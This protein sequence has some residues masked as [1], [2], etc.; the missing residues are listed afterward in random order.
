MCEASPVSKTNRTGFTSEP[1]ISVKPVSAGDQL[2]EEEDSSISFFSWKRKNVSRK[3]RCKTQWMR[4][5]DRQV[6]ECGCVPYLIWEYGYD[7]I[8]T[9][10]PRSNT[11]T[12]WGENKKFLR[13][14][15]NLL[16]PLVAR[17]SYLIVDCEN[18]VVRLLLLLTE[19]DRRAIQ[20]PFSHLMRWPLR[21]KITL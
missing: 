20:R 3:T 18:D 8:G 19:E 2:L 12:P 7:F 9:R 5:D 4:R 14:F 10:C 13:N 15:Q 1:T 11:W 6:D 17:S 16:F 21:F